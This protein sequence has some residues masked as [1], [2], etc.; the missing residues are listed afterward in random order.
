MVE[1]WKTLHHMY[2]QAAIAPHLYVLDNETS[3]D[4][5]T[6]FENAEVKHQL[7]PPNH[8]QNNLAERAIQTWKTHFKAGLATVNP[9][10]P[11]SEWDRLIEQANITLNLLRSSRANTKLSAYA[12]LFGQFN[13]QSTPLAPP[14]TKVIAH[15]NPDIRD[16]WELNGESGWYV[17]PALQ[18]YRCVTCYFHLQEVQE[19]VTQLNFY[20]Q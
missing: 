11:L 20:L 3:K 18:H 4:L 13:F 14:G 17:G 6:A 5:I 12:Y 9:N 16:S 10:F 7:V 1:T 15:I 19:Y 2:E 8:H